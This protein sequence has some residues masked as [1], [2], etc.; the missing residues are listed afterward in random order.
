[1]SEKV[2]EFALRSIGYGSISDAETGGMSPRSRRNR[3]VS[4]AL[5]IHLLY[6]N[7]SYILTVG[8]S[9]LILCAIGSDLKFIAEHVGVSTTILGGN[10]F[11]AR[12][13]GS[14]TGAVASSR[15]FKLFEGDRVLLCGLMGIAILLS[16]IPSV[17]SESALYFYFFSLGLFSAINDTG[18]NIMTRKIRDKQTGPWLGANG[19]SFGM[20]AAIVPIIEQISDDFATQYYILAGIILLVFFFLFNGTQQRKSLDDEDHTELK[21]Q[22]TFYKEFNVQHMHIIDAIVPHYYVESIVALMLFCLVGGQVIFVAYITPYILQSNIVPPE[23]TSSALSL[24]WTLVTAGRLIGVWDQRS[25]SDSRLINHLTYCCTA[26]SFFLLL[27]ILAPHS[28]LIFW[29]GLSAYALTY[30]P[31]VSYCYDLNNRLT[32]PTE[33]STSICMFGL[34]CGAS[35]VPYFTAQAWQYFGNN[36]VTLT[37]VLLLSVLIPIPLLHLA[38]HLSYNDFQGFALLRASTLYEFH[39]IASIES[40]IDDDEVPQ[41]TRSGDSEIIQ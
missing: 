18:C 8:V 33:Q 11:L 25:L 15:I 35:F 39:R 4:E 6:L 5:E 29:I 13:C 3:Q 2:L 30:G 22:E 26:G 27:M 24:F 10:A 20:S 34:N 12:G 31:T 19:I 36:P 21:R 32:L 38:P 37:V 28:P 1:M 7:I 16:V 41:Y 17:T 9:G 23:N 14:I 40:E